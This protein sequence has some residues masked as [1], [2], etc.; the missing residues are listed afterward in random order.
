MWILIDNPRSR[1]GRSVRRRIEALR[2]GLDRDVVERLL[3]VSIDE[4][5]SLDV[6][7]EKLFALGGDGTINAALS[8]LLDRRWDVPLGII[9]AGTGNNL[10]RRLHLPLGAEE[11]FRLGLSA[12]A[13]RPLDTVVI[14]SGAGERTIMVQSAALGFPADVAAR[15][16]RW[17]RHAL[18]RWCFR[19]LGPSVY[20]L[21]ALAGLAAQKRRERRGE[22]QLALRCRLDG[23]SIEASVLA[24]FIAGD[25]SLGGNF[26]PCPRARVDD[27]L[28]DICLVRAGTGASY[29]EL[30]RKFGRGAHL[31]DTRT[32]VYR[33]SRGPV[34]L[35]FSQP[36]P[37]LVDGDIQQLSDRFRLEL[38]PSRFHVLDA[39]H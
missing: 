3:W 19:P 16:D 18:L 23:E 26:L 14:T 29:L 9:P 27:G 2:S 25:G 4:L 36:T 5:G 15:Y 24:V 33:Q 17:R 1:K 39:A 35:E 30:F 10:A 13:G 34:E 21:L 20:R 32:V 8:W 38:I 11:A 12:S 6:Q 31:D 28:I 37:L 7:P 22:G